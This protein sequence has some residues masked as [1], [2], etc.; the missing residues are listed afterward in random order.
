MHISAISS[1][2]INTMSAYHWEARRKQNHL[3]RKRHSDLK[4]DELLTYNVSTVAVQ[5]NVSEN[6]KD[7]QGIHCKDSLCQLQKTHN[8]DD[9][10]TAKLPNR[11][12]SL[13]YNQQW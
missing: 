1:G 10:Y 6:T 12:N 5:K 3:D 7:I 13:Q 9:G 4:M 11:Y 2:N 8:D